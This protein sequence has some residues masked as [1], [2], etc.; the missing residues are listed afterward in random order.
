MSKLWYI[1][2]WDDENELIIAAGNNMDEPHK[3]SVIYAT[4]I[5]SEILQR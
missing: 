5:K 3:Q 2:T 1:H 4:Y